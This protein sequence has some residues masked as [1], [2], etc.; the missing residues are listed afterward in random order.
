MGQKAIAIVSVSRANSG[1][2]VPYICRPEAVRIAP[3]REKRQRTQERATGMPDLSGQEYKGI[4]K[5]RA[6]HPKEGKAA[7][8][9][10]LSEEQSIEQLTHKAS[11]VWTWNAPSYVT[12]DNYGTRKQ[13]EAS[14]KSRQKFAPET[15]D[16]SLG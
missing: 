3:P 14:N 15:G 1:K 12:G 10:H 7:F 9:E 5:S 8:R 13:L 11:A 6:A 4:L 2:H 16:R